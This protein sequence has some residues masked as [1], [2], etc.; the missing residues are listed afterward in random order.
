MGTSLEEAAPGVCRGSGGGGGPLLGSK[1]ADGVGGGCPTW[2]E[3][4]CT[5]LR[6]NVTYRAAYLWT[7][8]RCSGVEAPRLTAL[9]R[10]RG[11]A[12]LA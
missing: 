5:V 12:S 7:E 9:L 8:G 1:P 2:L 11:P 6:R 4:Y 10:W 3:A